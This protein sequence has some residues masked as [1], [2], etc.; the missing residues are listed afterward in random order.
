MKTILFPHAFRTVGWT[1]FLPALVLGI[2]LLTETISL[3]GGIETI[4]NDAAI[5]GITIGAL[6][7]TCSREKIEDEMT[8]SIRLSTLLHS[9]YVWAIL[10]I[11]CTLF[12][13]G[14]DYFYFMAINLVLLPLIFAALFRLEMKRYFKMNEDEE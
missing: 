11:A 4:C 2:L 10:L 1:L 6:F 3:S 8:R 9:I 5:I 13:N 12:I 7:I 14:L